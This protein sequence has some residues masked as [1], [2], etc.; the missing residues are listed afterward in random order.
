ML[1][2]RSIIAFSSGLLENREAEEADRQK[3]LRQARAAELED[4]RR[5]RARPP[6]LRVFPER[7]FRYFTEKSFRVVSFKFLAL[8]SVV[9]AQVPDHRVIVLMVT[10]SFLAQ[11]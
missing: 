3:R 6:G 1:P 10:G 2:I 4:L 9:G 7:P 5:I 11:S 8:W